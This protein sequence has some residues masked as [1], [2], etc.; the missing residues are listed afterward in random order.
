MRSSLGL[1]AICLAFTGG[2]AVAATD[3]RVIEEVIVTGTKR[4]T[5]QQDTPIAIST[6]TANDIS[7]TFGNDIRAIGDLSPNVNLTLQTGFNALAGGIRGTGT[8]SILTTQDPSVGILIDDFALSHVQTQFVELF[9]LQQVEVYRGPQGTL[10]GKNSTGGVISITSKRPD[11]ENFGGTFKIA[12]GGYDGGAD[13]SKAQ[14]GLDVPLIEGVLGLRFAGSYTKE[15]GFYENDKDTALFPNAPIYGLFG[16]DPADL[17]PELDTRTRGDG[18]RLG[19]KDVAAAKTKLLWQP[20]DN[21]EAYFIWEVVRDRSDSPPGINETPSGEG[22]LFELLGFP[23]IQA[24]GHSDPF[25]TGVTQ[26]GAGINI[27]DGHRVDI[28]GYYLNQRLDFEKFTIRSITGYREQEETLPSTY[29]GEAFISLFDATRNLEREQLQ[30]E[31]RLISNFDGP[32]N[33]VAGGIYIE[34]KLDFR[35]FAT[36]GLTAIIPAFNA[37][38]GSF[39]DDRGFINLDLRSLTGDPGA[40]EVKQDRES[41]AF[42]VDGTFEINDAWSLTLGV[43]HTKDEK[44]FYKPT[45]VPGPCNQ[46]T[47]AQD[48]I[49]VDDTMPFDPVTNCAGDLRSTSVSRAGITGEEIDQRHSPLPPSAYNFIA[50]DSEEWTET[51]WRAVVD[52][53]PNDDALF[54]FSIATGFLAGGYSE[55]CSQLVTCI[56]YDPETNTNYEIG[57]KGDFLDRRLRLNAAIFYT[58]FEDLQRNQVFAFTQANGDPGQETITLNAGESTAKGLEVEATWLVNDFLTVRGSLGYLDA[59]Y[60]QFSFDADPTDSIPPLDLT[61]LDVPF[62]AELQFG[63]EAIIDHTLSGGG[64]MQWTVGAH[65]QDEAETSPFDPNAA[66]AG[67]ARH[68]TNTQMEERTLVNA[69]VTYLSADERYHITLYGKNLTNEEYR[70]SANSVGALWNFTQ[71]GAPRQWGVEFGVNFQ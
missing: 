70:V 61:S 22:F 44:S 10:F 28:D 36:I 58:D 32:L 35:S 18:S 48:A 66:S 26:Q 19:G 53:K 55:T 43:R 59:E 12:A 8:I 65:Y 2:P 33:F 21:Y 15:Q 49:L 60:D 47:E 30:Q 23:G 9:D 50:D 64:S 63:I 52:W 38:T 69:N 62:A 29:T 45:G 13:T 57:F 46:Y 27:R 68:P 42:Y 39:L 40:G 5:S 56:N 17:P 41:L 51:T 20:T 34:D 11:L 67:T 16:L 31:F 25:S 3:E 24:A 71:Y 6:I 37:D 1:I 4:D 14:I 7:K 54:Y